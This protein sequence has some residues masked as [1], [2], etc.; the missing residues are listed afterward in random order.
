MEL[1]YWEKQL[2]LY[3]KAHFGRVNYEKDLKRFPAELYGLSLEYTDNYNV[4]GMVVRLYETLVK[5]GHINFSLET[6]ISNIFKRAFFDRSK[7]EVMYDD[8]VKQ[9]LSE[10]QNLAVLD[11]SGNRILDLGRADIKMKAIIT[12]EIMDDERLS[13]SN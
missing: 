4:L 11:N 2:I 3:T 7:H 9:I 8:V 1:H 10:F 12:K 13:V 5:M 6:F